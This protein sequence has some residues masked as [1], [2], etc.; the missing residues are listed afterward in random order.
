MKKTTIGAVLLLSLSPH[1]AEAQ[2]TI[3]VKAPALSDLYS[4]YDVAGVRLGMPAEDA[5][6]ILVRGGFSLR[7]P[8]YDRTSGCDWACSVDKAVASRQSRTTWRQSEDVKFIH[9]VGPRGQV[10]EVDF[11]PSPNGQ[12]V[13]MV[14]YAIPRSQITLD[15][16]KQQV[17]RKYGPLRGSLAKILYCFDVE[18][19]C[20]DGSNSPNVF[21]SIAEIGKGLSITYTPGYYYNF[22]LKE[23]SYLRDR[24]IKQLSQA[25]EALAPRDAQAAF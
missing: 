2:R 4:R 8:K 24:R 7:D 13:Q 18:P 1:S 25:V 21:P 17:S 11:A 12:I 5:Q 10:V 23:G 9:M 3:T 19:E 20:V 16:F 14:R 6:A 22:T 15:S